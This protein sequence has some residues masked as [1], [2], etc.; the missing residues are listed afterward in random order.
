M[1]TVRYDQLHADIIIIAKQSVSPDFL[2]VH[3]VVMSSAYLKIFGLYMF[4]ISQGPRWARIPNIWR[5]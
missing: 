3:K 1:F 2:T 5:C 4:R